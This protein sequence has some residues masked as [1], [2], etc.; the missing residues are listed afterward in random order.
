MKKHILFLLFVSSLGLATHPIC[1]MEQEATGKTIGTLPPEIMWW[2]IFSLLTAHNLT[3][4]ARVNKDFYEKFKTY[5]WDQKIKNEYLIFI[6]LSDKYQDKFERYD[7]HYFIEALQTIG[8]LVRSGRNILLDCTLYH[9]H[10]I[11][12]YPP[13]DAT[14]A[15]LIGMLSVASNFFLTKAMMSVMNRMNYQLLKKKY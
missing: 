5:F 14:L 13:P 15:H 8:K 12:D 7:S 9:Y 10:N 3:I 6:K 4:I 11:S 1:A 2:G